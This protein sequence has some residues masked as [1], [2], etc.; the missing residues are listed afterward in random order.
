MA[1]WQSD[2]DKRWSLFFKQRDWDWAE[3][4]RTNEAHVERLRQLETWRSADIQSTSDLA[5]RLDSKDRELLMRIEDLWEIEE[6]ALKR[7][8]ADLKEWLN[9]VQDS[10][11]NSPKPRVPKPGEKILGTDERYRRP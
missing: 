11:A 2:V 4:R 6:T 9:E 8:L 7:R 1:E 10:Q 3:Q 5:D